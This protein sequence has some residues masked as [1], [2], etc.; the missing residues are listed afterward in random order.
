MKAE[1]NYYYISKYILYTETMIDHLPCLVFMSH[2]KKKHEKNS[3]VDPALLK[4]RI[5]VRP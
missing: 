5:R 1:K 2:F 4:K 3:L